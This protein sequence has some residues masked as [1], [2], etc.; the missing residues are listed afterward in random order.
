MTK[1]ARQRRFAAPVPA[2]TPE[3]MRLMS[4]MPEP[5]V[6]V[7]EPQVTMAPA[8]VVLERMI[9]NADAAE[10]AWQEFVQRQYLTGPDSSR[11]A[12]GKR[13]RKKSFL[14]G[15]YAALRAPR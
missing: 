10:E 6:P 3:S 9:R 14:A 12:I 8:S 13:L 5:V 15:Y 4:P 7:P 1:R 2:E 11:R